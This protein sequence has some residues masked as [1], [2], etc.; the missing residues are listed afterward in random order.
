MAYDLS[1]LLGTSAGAVTALG[2]LYTA[3]RHL[4]YSV[5]AK[6]D[7]ERQD[8]LNKVNEEMA[9]LESKLEEKIRRLE[10]EFKNHKENLEKDLDY[11]RSSYNAEIK[12]L[13]DKIQLLREDLGAQ[14]SQ[15]ISLLTKL[16][17]N[18]N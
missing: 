10:E 9:K 18:N 11:M 5:Q 16:V 2:G 12:V 15:M 8:I 4:R 14:H 3:A 7:R 6:K 17:G 1:T 13:G